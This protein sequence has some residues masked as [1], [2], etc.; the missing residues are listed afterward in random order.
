[1]TLQLSSSPTV[2]YVV[3]HAFMVAGKKI[4]CLYW[5]I[6]FMPTSESN[7][8]LRVENLFHFPV[9]QGL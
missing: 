6:R 5:L 4:L 3:G 7:N 8:H 2:S 9:S 1:M